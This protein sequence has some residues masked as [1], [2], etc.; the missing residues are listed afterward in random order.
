MSHI[1]PN[2]SFWSTSLTGSWSGPSDIA[3]ESTNTYNSQNTNELKI[4]GSSV[5]TW[6]YMGDDWDADG[7]AAANYVW[8]PISIDSGSHTLTLQD[9]AY[10]RVDVNTGESPVLLKLMAMSDLI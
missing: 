10:W 9:Y 2:K 3:P 8:L 5:T 1:S 4:T 6:I 7:T